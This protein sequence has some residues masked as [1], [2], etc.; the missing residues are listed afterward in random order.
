MTTSSQQ[1]L[2]GILSHDFLDRHQHV[3]LGHLLALLS[4]TRV[5][6]PLSKTRSFPVGRAQV[7][8]P[9]GQWPL[10]SRHG[11]QA[12]IIGGI[13]GSIRFHLQNGTGVRL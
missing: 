4:D 6:C 7:V 10:N 2:T 13:I 3:Y 5:P 9:L 8:V 11:K 1:G 12:S